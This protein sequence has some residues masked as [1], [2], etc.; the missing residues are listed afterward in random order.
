MLPTKTKY[1][2]FQF[3]EWDCF[4]LWV[5][6]S[7]IK[8]KRDAFKAFSWSTSVI[9]FCIFLLTEVRIWFPQLEEVQNKIED[10]KSASFCFC[11]YSRCSP[12]FIANCGIYFSLAQEIW[13]MRVLRSCWKN[14]ICITSVIFISSLEDGQLPLVLK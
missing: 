5:W 6:E 1:L 9:R 8:S 10:Y 4:F 13:R 12:F 7:T 2:W 11:S 14:R 3:W